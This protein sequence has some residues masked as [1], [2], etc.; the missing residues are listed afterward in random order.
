ME[1]LAG[2]E[3]I[4]AG[5]EEELFRRV[6]QQAAREAL[7]RRWEQA[8]PETEAECRGCRQRMKGLG[9]RS[10]QLRTLCGE[11][12]IERRVYYCSS[13]QQTEAPLDRQL[14]LEQS[15]LDGWAGAGGLPNSF[16]TGLPA[17]P[18][19]ADRHVGLQPLL[20][21]GSGADRQAAWKDAGRKAKREQR[22]GTESWADQSQARLQIQILFG[23]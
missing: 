16:G 2:G 21:A 1:P 14:G 5:A 10:R 20:G 23:H 8:D 4:D 15:G 13:C 7:V 18:T 19:L 17:K 6:G 3:T 9:Q 12:R 11:V 22:A